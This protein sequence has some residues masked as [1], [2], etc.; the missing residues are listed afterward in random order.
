MGPSPSP[1][2]IALAASR[3]VD[4]APVPAIRRSARSC[5]QYKAPKELWG[6]TANPF[7]FVAVRASPLS[8]RPFEP[9]DLLPAPS[10]LL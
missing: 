4:V 8:P 10:S 1:R 7:A 5:S 6:Q 3:V 9:P 2:L